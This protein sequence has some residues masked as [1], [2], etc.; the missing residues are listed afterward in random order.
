MIKTLIFDFD[1]T[2]ADTFSI[3]CEAFKEIGQEIGL[4]E[5]TEEDIKNY[6]LKGAEDLIKEFRIMPWR[7]PTLIKKGQ[8]L[9]RDK[10]N[11]TQPFDQMPETLRRIFEKK[12]KMGIITTNSKRNVATFLKK[13][14]LEVFDFIVSAPSIFG[15]TKAIKR[16][17]KKYRLE[18]E[19][20]IYVG[21]EIRDIE[22]A[23]KAGIRVAAVIWGYNDFN[24]L[25]EGKPD[26]VIRKPQ[27][28]LKLFQVL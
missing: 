24:L 2:I 28:L 6:R 17:I 16:A 1:G 7:L 15:K 9:F 20:V 21:D 5:L 19:E 14:D 13:Y 23:Q 10:M 18:K 4:K 11:G 26:F 12:I 22:G 27:D 8:R 25:E 3:F